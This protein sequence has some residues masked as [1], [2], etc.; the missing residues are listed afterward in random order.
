MRR[1]RPLP[2]ESHKQFFHRQKK[3]ARSMEMTQPIAWQ[4]DMTRALAR[5]EEKKLPILLFFQNPD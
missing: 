3:P 2:E 1:Q 5:A 4:K